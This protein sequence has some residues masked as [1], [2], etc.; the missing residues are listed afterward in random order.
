MIPQLHDTT[1]AAELRDRTSET[2]R[3]ELYKDYP[4]SETTYFPFRYPTTEFG[5]DT[6]LAERFAG[7]HTSFHATEVSPDGIMKM[8]DFSS[9]IHDI[10]ELLSQTPPQLQ[11]L[12]FRRNVVCPSRTWSLKAEDLK[13]IFSR[14]HVQPSFVQRLKSFKFSASPEL[15]RSYSTDEEGNTSAK[16]HG[17]FRNQSIIETLY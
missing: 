17:M 11:L 8:Y 7:D 13:K 14:F 10:D 16:S 9:R 5:H 2:N 12:Y 1:N 4:R 15:Y 3:V 6:I